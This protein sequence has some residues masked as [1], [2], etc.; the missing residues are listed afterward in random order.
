MFGHFNVLQNTVQ[1]K[2]NLT[3]FVHFPGNDAVLLRVGVDRAACGFRRVG[4][5]VAAL[6]IDLRLTSGT[7]DGLRHTCKTVQDILT[8]EPHLKMDSYWL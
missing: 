1:E 3:I 6:L 7:H 5:T 8:L 2:P 4:L